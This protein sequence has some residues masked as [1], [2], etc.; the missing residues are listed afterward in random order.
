MKVRHLF[1]MVLALAVGITAQAQTTGEK[2]KK[3]ANEHLSLSGYLQGGFRWDENADPE[4]TFY[5]HRARLSLT[6]DAAQDKIDYRLQVDWAGSPK[7]C[8]LYFRYKP[9]NALNIELGQF[10]IPFSYE[11]E[12]CGPTTVEFIEYSYITTY[13]ARNN[14]RYDG[15][16]ATG[17]DFGFQVYGG[18]M[19][20]EG[21]NIINY[22]LGVFNGNG[23]NAKDNN[24]S[25]DLIARLVIKPFKGFAV[26]GSYMYAE[27][28]YNGNKFMKS[29]RWA[30][31][32][33]YDSRHWVARSEYAEAD[34][35]G[36]I[37]RAFYVLGGY[38]F[39]QPW[40][41]FARY[42]FIND[43]YR[44][45]DEQRIQIGAAY[46][47]FKFLRLQS[48]LSYTMP[49]MAVNG[50]SSLGFNLLVTAMF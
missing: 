5:L 25:K 11:N 41:L 15:I 13:L 46:K 43:E 14:A 4:T 16:A 35:G 17:R 31:G 21:Y 20:R 3:F 6:G 48:N 38:H 49:Y 19:E 10:K 28:S 7:I 50:K 27:T 9:L 30:V 18:F 32:A 36:N 1:L 39:E 40:S 22:N 29:P 23:I 12:N 8:D 42:E 47:P 37:T 2:I 34:F 24:S 44:I 26:T 33:L 45:M